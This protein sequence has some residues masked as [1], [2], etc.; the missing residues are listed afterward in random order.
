MNGV[1]FIVFSILFLFLPCFVTF[2]K[3]SCFLPAGAAA[4]RLERFVWERREHRGVEAPPAGPSPGRGRKRNSSLQGG[5]NLWLF[6]PQLAGTVSGSSLPLPAPAE[7]QGFRSAAAAGPCHSL[8]PRE[9]CDA[10]AHHQELSALSPCRC[11]NIAPN[12]PNPK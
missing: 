11:F 8:R 7:G 10:K 9:S 1:A 12:S 6:V 2:P 3:R 5:P 4:V